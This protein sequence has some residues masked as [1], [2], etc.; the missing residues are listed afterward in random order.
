[1]LLMLLILLSEVESRGL[2]FPYGLV[3]RIP[4]FYL[5]F[6]NWGQVKLKF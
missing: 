2:Q 5:G 1:M 6:G 3:I 4:G